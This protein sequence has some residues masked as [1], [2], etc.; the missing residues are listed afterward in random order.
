MLRGA[1]VKALAEKQSPCGK[2]TIFA[3][4]IDD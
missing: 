3:K 4:I 1:Q 2:K